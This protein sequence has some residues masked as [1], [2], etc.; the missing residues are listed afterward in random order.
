M[1]KSK[2]LG[3]TVILLA[4]ITTPAL[5]SGETTTRPWSAPVGHHQ[6]RAADV[7]TS[8][9]LSLQIRDKEDVDIDRKISNV[10]RGC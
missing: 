9:S 1:T 3:L 8:T 5:A 4:A 2:L 6:P 10:C 7:P